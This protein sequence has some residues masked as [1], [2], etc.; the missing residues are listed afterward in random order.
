MIDDPAQRTTLEIRLTELWGE[1][2]PPDIATV[3]G[4]LEG[5]DVVEFDRI[6]LD[7]L[8]RRIEIGRT[9]RLEDY[10]QALPNLA[11]RPKA[12]AA[13][14][15]CE[16]AQERP[17]DIAAW[18]S[19]RKVQLPGHEASVDAATQI[20]DLEG[21]PATYCA[22]RYVEIGAVGQGGFA[23]V[24][25]ARDSVSGAVVALK[26]LSISKDDERREIILR[27][28]ER[29]SRILEHLAHPGVARVLRL[30]FD[31]DDPILV[32]ELIGGRD[33]AFWIQHERRRRVAIGPG[34]ADRRQKRLVRILRLIESAALSI[35]AVHECGTVHR[36]LKPANIV[37]DEHGEPIIVDFGLAAFDDGRTKMTVAGELYGTPA[38]MSPE[39]VRGHS[40]E[41]DR[42]TDV[43]SLGVTLYECVTLERPFERATREGVFL[44]ILSEDAADPRDVEP[45]VS[46][47]L[48]LILST[49]LEKDLG[50]RYATALDFAEDLARLRL[51]KPIRARA[52]GQWR[53]LRKW[54]AKKP[55]LA[56]SLVAGLVLLAVST[57]LLIRTVEERDAKNAALEKYDRLSDFGVI[58]RMSDESTVAWP[59]LP[60]RIAAYREWLE[61]AARLRDN[62]PIHEAYLTELRNSDHLEP[63]T[64]AEKKI[65]Q[66]RLQRDFWERDRL[67]K[68]RDRIIK[69]IAVAESGDARTDAPPESSP[70]VHATGS[71][72]DD[73]SI[74][75]LKSRFKATEAELAAAD[76]RCRRRLTWN[77]RDGQTQYLHDTTQKIVQDLNKFFDAS[78]HIGHFASIQRR[79]K[80]AETVEFLTISR[81]DRSAMWARAIASIAD[82]LEC[83]RYQG[84]TIRPQLGLI[85]IRKDPAS[86]LWE[87]A[88]LWTTADGTDPIPEIG[89]DN[90]LHPKESNGIIFVLLPGGVFRMGARRPT[91]DESE[92]AEDGIAV[93]S[94]IDI[95]ADKDESPVYDVEL[96]PFFLSKYEVTQAQWLRMTGSNPSSLQVGAVFGK[97]TVRA[98]HPVEQVSW[99]DANLAFQRLGWGLPTEAQWE[100][101]ARAGTRTPWWTGTDPTRLASAENIRDQSAEEIGQESDHPGEAWTDGFPGHAPIGSFDPNPFGLHDMLGNVREW[102]RD[103]FTTY[104]NNHRS[105]DGFLGVDSVGPDATHP[106]RGGA[107]DE[108]A[109][110]SRSSARNTGPASFVYA[111]NGVRPCRNVTP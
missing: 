98:I 87:F 82:P 91:R 38:Y 53:Q 77:F 67:T 34:A 6:L 40:H 78:P 8:R 70:I 88:D 21:T 5:A 28:L 18:C 7:D 92:D 72:F 93:S 39:Q 54:A 47:D 26:R 104:S 74:D 94:D 59:P 86:G 61:K 22:G 65:D 49:A 107:Y 105:G 23:S 33:L 12:T 16:L 75:E 36:D 20:A 41:I 55:A 29:E 24:I 109:V 27:R 15:G 14:L 62:R 11:T 108:T 31:Q 68:V 37:V 66:G 13:I 64:E 56:A 100:Y 19:V 69:A 48:G 79:L 102:A 73:M 101:A 57:V 97:R 80:Y 32:L 83:P 9:I 2:D 76:A 43:Y 52:P 10:L 63:Y 42:R 99:T 96:A 111:A 90:R 17:A 103:W 46:R 35:H 84:Q 60:S 4:V 45:S 30:D 81:P 89:A 58:D 85:P 110:G 25:R 51:G 106:F 95:H 3:F 71:S 50:R 1:I 44:A